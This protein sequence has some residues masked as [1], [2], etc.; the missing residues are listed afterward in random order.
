MLNQSNYIIAGY[1]TFTLLDEDDEI[2]EATEEAAKPEEAQ[3]EEDVVDDEEEEEDK[4]VESTSRCSCD[5]G[6]VQLAGNGAPVALN[7]S[8]G[9][10]R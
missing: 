3:E 9:D 10:R 2:E 7:Q 5:M 4:A 6:R 1:C 8:K